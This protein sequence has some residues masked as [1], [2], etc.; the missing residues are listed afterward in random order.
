MLSVTV[1]DQYFYTK[2]PDLNITAREEKNQAGIGVPASG[3]IFTSGLE[4]LETRKRKNRDQ[5][6]TPIYVLNVKTMKGHV[7]SLQ[8]FHPVDVCWCVP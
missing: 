3:E 1:P 4:C 7:S 5:I 8:K 2:H 6:E